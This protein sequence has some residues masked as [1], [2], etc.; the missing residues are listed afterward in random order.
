MQA[1]IVEATWYLH[2]DD[3]GGDWWAEEDCSALGHEV[4]EVREGWGARLSAPGYMDATS[5][6]VYDSEDE[7]QDD[8]AFMYDLCPQ[9][10]EAECDCDDAAARLREIVDDG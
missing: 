8:L 3:G 6:G 5:W 4:I 10:L 7:A 9:C 2:R 1:E